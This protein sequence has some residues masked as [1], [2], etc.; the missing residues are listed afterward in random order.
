[1]Q[2]F[3]VTR[4]HQVKAAKLNV[5]IATNMRELGYGR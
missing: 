2:G 5:A 1:M 4:E 3:T